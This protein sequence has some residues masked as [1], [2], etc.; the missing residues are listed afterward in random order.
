MVTKATAHGLDG[1]PAGW[2]DAEVLP[3]VS[4]WDK[5]ELEGRLFLVTAVKQTMSSQNYAM[6]WVEGELPDGTMFTFNDSSA[7]VGVRAEVEELLTTLKKADQ[8]DEWIPVRFV[9][10]DG[11]RVSRYEKE[12]NRG[13]MQPFRTYYFTRS[14][15]R[16]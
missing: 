6:A 10:P 8:L 7:V 1:L 12:D 5:G 11:L 9:C 16:A 3:G 2:A 4:V 15:K 14:G 13:K